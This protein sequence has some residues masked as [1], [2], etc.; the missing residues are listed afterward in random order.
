MYISENDV[1]FT[2]S[3]RLLWYEDVINLLSNVSSSPYRFNTHGRRLDISSSVPQL[4]EAIITSHDRPYQP[5]SLIGFHASQLLVYLT[6]TASSNKIS[7]NGRV[8][9]L[10]VQIP[11]HLGPLLTVKALTSI[12]KDRVLDLLAGC[13]DLKKPE[14]HWSIR[15]EA[16]LAVYRLSS[17]DRD[18][19]LTIT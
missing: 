13:M 1:D 17:Q 10:T 4:F 12:E 3:G 18:S 11:K 6:I 9:N 8:P 7:W 19:K 14:I 16:L 5:Y 15:A 2:K